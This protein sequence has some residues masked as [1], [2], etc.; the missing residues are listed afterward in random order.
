MNCHE[1]IYYTEAYRRHLA[2][3]EYI[4]DGK[5]LKDTE[6][7]SLSEGFFL[8]YENYSDNKISAGILTLK[9]PCGQEI[10]NTKAYDSRCIQVSELFT[11]SDG[12]KYLFYCE[13][14]YGY[15]VLRLEGRK[16]MHYIPKGSC[17]KGQTVGESFITVNFNYDPQTNIAAA[18]GCFRAAPYDVAILDM[19]EP[20]REPDKITTLFPI[21]NPE[22][23]YDLIGEIEFKE[24]QK[25]GRL[26]ITADTASG[27]E[28]MAFTAEALRSFMN[29]PPQ[30]ILL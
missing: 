3:L 12:R 10:F 20:L 14:L 19:S 21:I 1:N 30:E 22:H 25:G 28:E 29:L 16:T 6:E 27:R 18:D 15:S 11:H 7:R 26:I 5:Y 24:W 2:E 4:F 9:D 8:E 13:D 23:D 17:R